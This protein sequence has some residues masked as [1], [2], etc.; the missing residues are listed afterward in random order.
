MVRSGR[1]LFMQE[2]HLTWPVSEALQLLQ[3][4]IRVEHDRQ[5]PVF[6]VSG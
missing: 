5:S 4:G 2:R 1:Y 6:N 3:F